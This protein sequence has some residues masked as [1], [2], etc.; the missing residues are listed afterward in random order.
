MIFSSG[1]RSPAPHHAVND[2][3]RIEPLN[4]LDRG[5]AP[6]RTQE[7]SASGV[8]QFCDPRLRSDER[9]APFFTP[10]FWTRRCNG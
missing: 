4:F 10:Y 9:F 8:D 6:G 1:T 5:M 2:Y 3:F 7:F